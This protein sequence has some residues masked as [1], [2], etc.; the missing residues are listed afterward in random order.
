VPRRHHGDRHTSQ[1]DVQQRCK[2]NGQLVVIRRKRFATVRQY[3]P[4][5]SQKSSGVL[6][7]PV[8]A[9][10]NRLRTTKG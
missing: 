8:D 6:I 1:F 5:R 7:A 10:P 9:M 4:A 2:S 3:V